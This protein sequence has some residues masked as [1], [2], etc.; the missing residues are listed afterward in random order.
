MLNGKIAGRLRVKRREHTDRQNDLC[1]TQVHVKCEESVNTNVVG[2]VGIYPA[3]HMKKIH[4]GL[5]NERIQSD[6]GIPSSTVT[7]YT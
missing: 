7:Q 6:Y 4:K 3:K 1:R 2:M 5:S